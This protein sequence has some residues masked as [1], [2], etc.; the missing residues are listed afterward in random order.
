MF[1]RRAIAEFVPLVAS[2]V[3]AAL[4]T[5]AIAG[6]SVE[7]V[8]VGRMRHLSASNLIERLESFGQYSCCAHRMHFRRSD[9]P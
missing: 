9:D 1:V 4:V 2:V 6:P 7:Q 8:S 3:L 5:E